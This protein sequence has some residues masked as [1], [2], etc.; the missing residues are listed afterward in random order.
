MIEIV[1]NRM[2]AMGI[3]IPTQKRP[4]SFVGNFCLDETTPKGSKQ[5][6]ARIVLS[7]GDDS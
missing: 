4:L 6:E 2:D 1:H 7:V 3:R 5:Q